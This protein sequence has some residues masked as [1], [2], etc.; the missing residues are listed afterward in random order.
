MRRLPDAL[1]GA[2]LT[3]RIH[4]RVSCNDEGISLGQLMIGEAS[5]ERFSRL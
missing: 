1:R 3:P 4:R 2:G 5:F